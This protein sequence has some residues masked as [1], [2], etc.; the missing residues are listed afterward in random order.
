[1]FHPQCRT[2]HVIGSFVP[3]VGRG[4]SLSHWTS[5]WGVGIKEMWVPGLLC[6]S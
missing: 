5:V 3:F 6:L 2:P 1:M 4:Y